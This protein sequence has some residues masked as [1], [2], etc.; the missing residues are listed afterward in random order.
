M[1]IE[2]NDSGKYILY[3]SC[4]FR[5]WWSTYIV[6]MWVEMQFLVFKLFPDWIFPMLDIYSTLLYFNFIT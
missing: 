6:Y 2:S 4:L 1:K 3:S 5:I